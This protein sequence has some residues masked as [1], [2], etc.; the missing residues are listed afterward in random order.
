MSVLWIHFASFLFLT[1]AG[2]S[3]RAASITDQDYEVAGG[4][5]LQRALGPHPPATLK[6]D[7]NIEGKTFET[8]TAFGQ[9]GC[10]AKFEFSIAKT[11]RYS[12]APHREVKGVYV[13][14]NT[15]YAC[16]LTCKKIK[17]IQV[18]RDFNEWD[19]DKNHRTIKP[20]APAQ[21]HEQQTEQRAGWGD[22]NSKSRGWLV[23]TAP[24]SKEPF[25]GSGT[26][27]VIGSEEDGSTHTPVH[28]ARCTKI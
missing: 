27:A 16:D 3:V 2:T 19:G 7:N 17:I 18:Y 15:S 8:D 20:E 24:D 21:E 22:N 9:K 13:R 5:G 14:I 25:Y 26:S 23:D 10:K 6:A 4:G 1:D 11:G 28:R 12:N